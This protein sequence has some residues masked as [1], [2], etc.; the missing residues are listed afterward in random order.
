MQPTSWVGGLV[1]VSVTP[2]GRRAHHAIEGV[3]RPVEMARS[4]DADLLRFRQRW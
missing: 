1:P 3:G 4:R 2:D